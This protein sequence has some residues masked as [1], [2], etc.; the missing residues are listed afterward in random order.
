MGSHL[1]D[2]YLHRLLP[3][4]F[5]YPCELDIHIPFS[6]AEDAMLANLADRDGVESETDSGNETISSENVEMAGGGW[7]ESLPAHPPEYSILPDHPLPSSLP[8]HHPNLKPELELQDIDAFIASVR[9]PP[10]PSAAKSPDELDLDLPPPPPALVTDAD[11]TPTAGGGTAAAVPGESFPPPPDVIPQT[12]G[13]ISSSVSKTTTTAAA[14]TTSQRLKTVSLVPSLSRDIKLDDEFSSLIIPPPPSNSETEALR[15]IPIVPPVN[16]KTPSPPESGHVVLRDKSSLSNESE[17]TEKKRQSLIELEE[18]GP[19]VAAL[20]KNLQETTT[21][22]TA[23]KSSEK[24]TAT[25]NDGSGKTRKMSAEGKVRRPKVQPPPPPAV[26]MHSYPGTESQSQSLPSSPPDDAS[27]S[28]AHASAQQSLGARHHPY[29]LLEGNLKP[30]HLLWRPTETKSADNSP[31]HKPN[32]VLDEQLRGST[33]TL[34]RN[35]KG[36]LPP[37][38]PPRR[39]SIPVSPSPTTVTPPVPSHGKSNSVDSTPY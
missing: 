23:E 10:P 14:G 31:V 7:P 5:P 39:S 28:S 25:T 18:K 4:G 11:K 30:S 37:V 17:A 36:M 21:K 2:I 19:S 3:T 1:Q 34:T 32:K 15:E 6:V 27:C 22:T 35:K 20:A 13:T 9:V 8:Q 12:Q 26:R 16:V 38:P 29:V 33:G 24:R